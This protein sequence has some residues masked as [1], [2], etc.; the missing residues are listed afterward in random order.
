MSIEV[1]WA[2]GHD[3]FPRLH[4]VLDEKA[5]N[6]FSQYGIVHELTAGE[7]VFEVDRP[8]TAL[9]LVVNGEIVIQRGEH[10]VARIG[11]NHSFGEMGLLLD[12]PR[13]AGAAAAIESRVLELSREDL[14]RMQEESPVWAARLYRVLAECLAEYLHRSAEGLRER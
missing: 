1:Q 5:F 2:T 13:S 7:T 3:R 14:H 12:V 4:W 9:Y 8:S 6:A 10:E 11:P